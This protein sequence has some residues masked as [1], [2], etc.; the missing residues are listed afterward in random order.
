MSSGI[1]NW[2]ALEF[3][4]KRF[5]SFRWFCIGSVF[6][7]SSPPPP[8]LSRASDPRQRQC[9]LRHELYCQLRLCA[10]EARLGPTS[11][12]QERGQFDVASHEA[13]GTEN[14][15]RD[16]LR[17]TAIL[18]SVNLLWPPFSEKNKRFYVGV[19]WRQQ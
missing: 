13:E 6:A 10:E 3:Q 19:S 18:P 11:A 14:R 9:F 2:E 7:D 1:T 16:F 15:K 17:C 5:S 12:G 4:L 8:F